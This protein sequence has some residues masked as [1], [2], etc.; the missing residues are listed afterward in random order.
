LPFKVTLD[1][2]LPDILN[3]AIATI[4][5]QYIRKA[6]QKTHGNVGRCAKI[7]GLSRR[8]ITSKITQYGIEKAI[9][10]EE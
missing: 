3:E 2:H 6:L 9:F 8:S 1:E 7:C 10:K 5:R 4:E